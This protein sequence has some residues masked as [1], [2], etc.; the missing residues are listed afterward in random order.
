MRSTS[1]ATSG[2]GR[3]FYA[4]SSGA[5]RAVF[6]T[7]DSVERVEQRS[8]LRVIRDPRDLLF[9]LIGLVCLGLD[10][11]LRRLIVREVL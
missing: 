4:G 8:L 5:L 3:Y 6:E 9:I 11:V 10:F 1:P 7:I 2:G